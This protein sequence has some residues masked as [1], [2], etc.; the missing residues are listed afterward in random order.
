M[1]E[2]FIEEIDEDFSCD[3]NDTA[4]QVEELRIG[5]GFKLV[6]RKKG[7]IIRSV[8]FNKENDRENYFKEQLMLY[9]PWR[10]ELNDLIEGFETYA[11]RYERV[12]FEV[13]QC[14]KQYEHHTEMLDKALEHLQ[15][16]EDLCLYSNEA[17]NSQHIDEQDRS[18][19]SRKSGLYSCFE[20]G[21][22]ILHSK[23]D[24]ID[25]IRMFPRTNDNS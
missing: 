4:L 8:R 13:L 15:N 24:L 10:N 18:V 20:P 3:N 19:P 22:N 21:A 14:K 6:K 1:P 9:T 11:D 25:D 7:K 16:E 5:N 23:Y 2:K 12:Q 17:A